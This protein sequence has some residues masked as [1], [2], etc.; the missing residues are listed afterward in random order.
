MPKNFIFLWADRDWKIDVILDM[1][2]SDILIHYAYEDEIK[3]WKKNESSETKYKH[4]EGIR[5]NPMT[6]KNP[7][8]QQP[9]I[10]LDSG[11][12]SAWKQGVEIDIEKYIDYIK[13]NAER[14][15]TYVNLDVIPGKPNVPRTLDEVEASAKASY[16]NLQI[17]KRAG[18][19]PIPVFH[20][21]E[22]LYWLD[23]LIKDGHDYIGISPAADEHAAAIIVW[24]DEVFSTITDDQGRATIKTHGFGVASFDIMKRYPW[25]TC[26]ATSWALTAGYGSIY[27]PIYRNGEPDYSMPPV[28]LTI[29]EADRKNGVPPDHYSRFGPLMRDR[30]K[31][32]LEKE[33]GITIKQAE[34]DYDHRA[35]AVVFFYQRFQQ[36][37]GDV[38][39][40][41]KRGFS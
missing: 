35:R 40:K 23:R 33:V 18:L 38:R 8:Q 22:R 26:D 19:N 12:Y 17:M 31:H 21:G 7:K 30:V 41:H 9:R 25:H 24:L 2:A 37:I 10:M 5:L 16:K 1:E 6:L 15:D 29:S 27:V 4:R 39:F 13:D 36:A 11:A 14:L 3:R 34:T 32:F 28:K 20:M